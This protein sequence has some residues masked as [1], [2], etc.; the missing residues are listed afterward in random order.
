MCTTSKSRLLVNMLGNFT[1][2]YDGHEISLGKVSMSKTTELFQIM[3]LYIKRGIPKVRILHAL[4]GVENSI[5]KNRSMNNLIYRLKQ[6]LKE[7]GIVQE[8]YIL[9]R[10]GICKWNSEIEVEVDADRFY[11]L[12]ENV[13]NTEGEQKLKLLRQAFSLYNGEFLADE[14]ELSWVTE[15]RLRFKKMYDSC[16]RE[17]AEILDE[18]GE[19]E[20]LLSVYAK[21]VK[22]YPFEEWQIGLIECLQKLGRFEEAREIY[23]RTIQG[24]F[25]N[26]GLP[27]SQNILDKVRSMG[28]E[29]RNRSGNIEEIEAALKESDE[30]KGA[31]CCNYPSFV[32][33]YRHTSRMVERNGKSIF[34]MIC[35]VMYLNSSGRKSPNADM[36]LS[37]AIKSALRKGDVFAQYSKHQ[38][39]IL[40]TGTQNENC[41]MIFERIRK[42]FKKKN[43]NPNCDLEY[44]ASELLEFPEETKRLSFRNKSVGWK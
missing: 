6:Q 22:L 18:R 19:Y 13:Q 41:E 32:N 35:S 11:E 43:R 28:M 31:Y 39:V 20:E 23:Q 12:M 3:M 15:E 17:L 34:F 14:A 21:A 29:I 36:I 7:S 2:T 26:V 40:L 4:Y 30:E 33:I 44:H 25:D 1:V 42:N 8:E 37:E 24:Y 5:D 27:L 16:V 38:F 10:N 9:I